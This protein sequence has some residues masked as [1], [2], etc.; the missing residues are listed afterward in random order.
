MPGKILFVSLHR[1]N[2]S[3]SQRFRFEQYIHF[4]EQ[5]GFNCHHSYLLSAKDDSVFYKP[6]NFL[7][8]ALILF[9]STFKRITEV[10][11]DKYDIVFVQRECYMLGTAFFEKNFS[12]K[13]KMV[14]DFDDSIW[15]NQTGEIKSGNK[16]FYFLKDP[17]KTE[18]IIKSAHMVFAG[19]NYLAEYASSYNQNVHIVPTTIDTDTYVKK[20]IVKKQEGICI[21]WSGSFSTIVHFQHVIPALKILK[22]KYSDKIYFKVI[23]D[24]SYANAELEIK[25]LPWKSETEVED[26]SEID[27]G[28]M[29]LPDDE[30]TKGKCGLKGLQYMAL[31]IPAVMSPVGVNTEIIQD[32]QN[33]FLASAMTEWV[34]KISILVENSSLRLQIGEAGRQTVLEKYSVQANKKLYLDLL[35]QILK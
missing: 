21:G 30:W 3:P 34:E 5:E 26:L 19:N 11:F 22:E 8:K 27:I 35:N 10:V 13:A 7:K 29:P 2:R 15:M 25:G 16:I 17:R 1:P 6:G 9:K 4:L 14:F 24:A 23:G 20:K 28:L 18:R 32:G 31:S 33:G 12:R